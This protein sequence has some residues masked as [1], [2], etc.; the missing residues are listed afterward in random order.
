M[1]ESPLLQNGKIGNLEIKNRIAMAPMT[2]GRAS[3]DGVPKEIMKVYYQQRSNAGLIISEGTFISEQGIGWNNAPGIYTKEQADAWK[4]I[5]AAVKD[6]GSVFFCQ[7]WHTGR[8]S[9][10]SFRK[11]GRLPF[12]PSA[13][14]INAEYV[15]TPNGKQAPEVPKEMTIE[16]IKQ[17]V[18]DFKNAAQFAKDAGF[19]GIEIH[20]ANGYL[21]DTFLQSKTNQRTDNYG[22]SFENRFRFLSEVIEAV[23]KVFPS[24]NVGVRLSPNGVYNDMGSQDY[25]ES[26][27]YYL[28]ELNKFNLAYVHI[29]DGLGFGFHNLGEQ[30]TLDIARKHYNGTIISNCGYTIEDGVKAISENKSDFV[31]Y[32]RP[33]ISNPDLVNRI[34]N[35]W[36]I[37][38]NPGFEYLYSD[39]EKG[40]I[41]YTN[42]SE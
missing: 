36:P 9:H 16:D 3:P 6:E 1:S 13:I 34:K 37:N 12:A 18:E 29:M 42:Y 32:G 39:G 5:T 14:A 28:D 40:Y 25:I 15:H 35:N 21:L 33:Y 41:D 22:G 31:A 17:T 2:R 23:T 30:F 24:E 20:S 38:E 7:L 27:S 26:Y 11:D 4:P 10:S 8:A 19:D